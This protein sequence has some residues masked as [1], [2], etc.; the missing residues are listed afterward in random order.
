MNGGV[1]VVFDPQVPVQTQSHICGKVHFLAQAIT[2]LF[3]SLVGKLHLN[4]PMSKISEFSVSPEAELA[5]ESSIWSL[6]DA[7]CLDAV[8]NPILRVPVCL[9]AELS[10]LDKFGAGGDSPLTIDHVMAR[11]HADWREGRKN[12]Y[13][14]FWILKDYL[15]PSTS[16]DLVPSEWTVVIQRLVEMYVS[17]TQRNPGLALADH[18]LEGVSYSEISEKAAQFCSLGAVPC[19]EATTFFESVAKK[20]RTCLRVRLKM[21]PDAANPTCRLT[22][23][24]PLVTVS[25]LSATL[26]V[27]PIHSGQELTVL[28]EFPSKKKNPRKKKKS[29]DLQDTREEIFHYASLTPFAF[30]PMKIVKHACSS[31]QLAFQLLSPSLDLWRKAHLLYSLDISSSSVHVGLRVSQRNLLLPLM[32]HIRHGRKTDDRL[33]ARPFLVALCHIFFHENM[34]LVGDVRTVVVQIARELE[35][36]HWLSAPLKKMMAQALATSA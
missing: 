4:I 31:D 19:F 8:P 2:E 3:P 12:N 34:R 30:V 9:L 28:H 5:F 36:G 16:A 23:L 13:V 26:V 15:L 33:V 7:I 27:V 29:K 32:Q 20:P 1:R 22:C 24:F 21:L 14:L 25:N 10:R 11:V 17:G 6:L 18:I 35:D